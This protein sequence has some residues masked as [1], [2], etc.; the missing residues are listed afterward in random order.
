VPGLGDHHHALDALRQQISALICA[1]SQVVRLRS[2]CQR[3]VTPKSS[4][5]ESA[6]NCASVGGVP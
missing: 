5:S 3:T 2:S 6:I 1:F 4:R